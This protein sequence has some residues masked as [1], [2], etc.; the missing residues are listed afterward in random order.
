M[1]NINFEYNFSLLNAATL[2]SNGVKSFAALKE[3][4]EDDNS[5]FEVLREEKY[6]ILAVIGFTERSLP[7]K[8]AFSNVEGVI[9]FLDARIAS[10]KEIIEEF[11]KYCK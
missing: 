1:A 10:K 4:F 7:I 11:C 3:V 5:Q 2:R 8:I 6:P 9:T